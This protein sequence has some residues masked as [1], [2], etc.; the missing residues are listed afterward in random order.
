MLLKDIFTKDISRSIDGVVKVWNDT[1]SVTQIELQEYVVTKEIDK[2]MRTFFDAL[3]SSETQDVYSTW[4]WISWFFG[5]WKSH[6]LKIMWLLLQN[7]EIW[8]KLPIQ[9]FEDKV[10]D[11]LFYA[12]IKKYIESHNCHTVLFNI[13]AISSHHWSNRKDAIVESCMKAF[14]QSLWFF[15]QKLWLADKERRLR[16]DWLYDDFKKTFQEQNGSSWETARIDIDLEMWAAAKAFMSVKDVEE[17]S[18]KQWFD[19]KYQLDSYEI[20]PQDF[21]EIIKA[22]CDI[23]WWDMRVFFM[24]DEVGQYMWSNWWLMLNLQ[25]VTELLWTHTRWKAWTV[26]TSQEAIDSVTN[27]EGITKQDFSKIKWRFPTQLSLSS[28]NVDEVIQKR[29]LEKTDEA[30]KEL[31]KIYDKE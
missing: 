6:F 9:Y 4:V 18:A 31:L 16:K 10:T 14:F 29:I 25:T 28:S 23:S 5:S 19:G 12:E 24:I 17:E 20:S 26:I 11:K 30:D 1:Q 3:H 27:M 15:H 2:H 7:K 8:G 13:D 21:A 22:F